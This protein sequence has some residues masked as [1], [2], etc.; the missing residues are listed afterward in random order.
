M[1][2]GQPAEAYPLYW[3][4]SWTR[5]APHKRQRAAYKVSPGRAMD[6]LQAELRRFNA[7]YVVISSNIPLR[8]D[9]LPRANSMDRLYDDP[10]VAVYF[11]RYDET[12]R[13]HIPHV[14]AC[15]RWDLVHHNMRAVGQ[16]IE[17]MRT[18][19]RTG[20]LE[21]LNR[22]FEGF[23]ALPPAEKPK[24]PWWEVFGLQK[25]GTSLLVVE[26]VYK[27]RAQ[28]TH[29]DKGGDEDAFKELGQ[30]LEDAKVDLEEAR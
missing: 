25:E 30:A 6:D 18:I 2:N 24:R 10:G 14:M 19:E 22:A 7:L 8:L 13:E 17:A 1:S 26:A 28:E 21:L 12:S 5:T 3:P 29:P 11:S 4:E 27:A 15:D 20:A 16:T 9:G 23:K